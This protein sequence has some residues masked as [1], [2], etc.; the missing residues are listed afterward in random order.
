MAWQSDYN[1]DVA[2]LKTPNSI[3]A[4]KTAGT[5]PDGKPRPSPIKEWKRG[6]QLKFA[7]S[8]N[9]ETYN[10]NNL[11]GE[12]DGMNEPGR[13]SLCTPYNCSQNRF[14][15]YPYLNPFFPP[16]GPRIQELASGT[17]VSFR[18]LV[19]FVLIIWF[20]YQFSKTVPDIAKQVAKGMLIGGANLG[21]VGNSMM[22][23]MG[24]A[25][26]LVGRTA[27][28]M[29]GRSFKDDMRVARQTFKGLKEG[30][31]DSTAENLTKAR[32]IAGAAANAAAKATVGAAANKLDKA[33]K[34]RI[35]NIEN[36]VGNKLASG[37]Y[38]GAK[39]L[40]KSPYYLAKGAHAAT[41]GDYTPGKILEKAGQATFGRA[42]AGI[43][44]LKKGVSEKISSKAE[45]L[46]DK[47]FK[48]KR[49]E[50]ISKA[51]QEELDKADA[52]TARADAAKADKAAARARIKDAKTDAERTK[53][54][55]DEKQAQDRV[56]KA[57]K[58]AVKA[59]EEAV[60]AGSTKAMTSLSNMY[61][62]GEGVDQS[63]DEGA[64]LTKAMELN[65]DALQ[66]GDESA[67]AE[68][69][70]L[71]K[72]IE[73]YNEAQLQKDVERG[74]AAWEQKKKASGGAQGDG[75]SQVDD[76]SSGD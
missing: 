35:G 7:G 49:P 39:M 51:A 57:S 63:L 73:R 68:L 22:G 4:Y 66:K 62:N 36:R 64:R 53:A 54:K 24:W 71:D 43:D 47:I 46:S 37:L 23:G 19:V 10:G 6:D 61:A 17:L 27:Y 13:S 18:G 42:S 20:M 50:R 58:D 60:K 9:I 28:G 56:D 3:L 15:G 52:A 41:F 12:T 48:T 74:H 59:Y 72:A 55:D 75:S 25:A 44:S 38:G 40:A 70:K 11:C 30:I 31:Q 1:H 21:A 16:D 34:N 45:G 2:C 29:T 32:A 26:G 67:R 14:I 33:I 5:G 76:G 8:L 69:R 65:Q